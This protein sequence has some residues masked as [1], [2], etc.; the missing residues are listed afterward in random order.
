M[1]SSILN[2]IMTRRADRKTKDAESKRMTSESTYP[3]KSY[4][5]FTDEDSENY[6]IYSGDVPQGPRRKLDSYE[7]NDIEEVQF[8]KRGNG[9]F[10]SESLKKIE[11]N[12]VAF[13]NFKNALSEFEAFMTNM[14]HS[15]ET[16]IMKFISNRAK[17][18]ASQDDISSNIA[19]KIDGTPTEM[20]GKIVYFLMDKVKHAV[21]AHFVNNSRQNNGD[22]G[23]AIASSALLT[24]AEFIFSVIIGL[25]DFVN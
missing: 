14:I 10:W 1:W 9:H 22:V 3:D 6:N 11:T 21:I 25:P 12:E 24:V 15:G 5:S 23:M 18:Q 2:S 20:V 19:R 7:G 16:D 17:I 13:S 8:E 4:K